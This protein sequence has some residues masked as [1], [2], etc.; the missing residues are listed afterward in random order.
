M[1]RRNSTTTAVSYVRRSTDR[2]EQSIDDQKKVLQQY[3]QEHSIRL[4]QFYIDDAISGT[5]T[6]KRKAF[7][8]MI[9]D[10]ERPSRKFD[11]IV[12]YDVKRFGRVDNDEAGFYRHRLKMQ[13]VEVIYVTENFNGDYTDDLLRP[14]KQW[15]ARQESKDLS[16]VTIRGLLSKANTGWWL[17]GV[18]PYG[19]DLLYQ[20]CDNEFL[21]ILRFMPDG[22]K[23][24]LDKNQ[25][26]VRTLDR[27]QRLSI[28]KKDDH[29]TLVCSSDDRVKVA[30]RIF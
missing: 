24:V 27:G 21:H 7:L 18:P 22:T 2:Q 28:S 14:V 13:G 1:I 9:D 26:L 19:Y 8:Q 25:K 16:K 3:A 23:R 11:S 12:V 5:Y 30:R 6:L 10:A 29:A 17:G 4:E 15:Q 20:S